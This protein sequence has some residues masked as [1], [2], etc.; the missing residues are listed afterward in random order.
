M[1]NDFRFRAKGEMVM[2]C[3]CRSAKVKKCAGCGA[4][5]KGEPLK[6]GEKEYCC[7]GCAEKSS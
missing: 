3:G 6:K 4:E 1:P 5:I 7:K 2:G